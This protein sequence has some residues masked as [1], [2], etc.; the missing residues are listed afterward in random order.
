ML[1]S[2]GAL[3]F[4][5]GEFDLVVADYVFEHLEDPEASAAELSRVVKPGGWLCARTPNYYGY[6][7]VLTRLLPNRVHVR[8]LAASQPDRPQTDVFPT[9][10]ALNTKRRI[11]SAFS[12]FDVHVYYYEAE[13]GYFFNRRWVFRL[14]LIA[15]KLLPRSLHSSLFAFM[16]KPE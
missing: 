8:I 1:D 16:H 11:N 14:M 13:P 4:S 3:P 10:F 6:V 15:N 7:S 12:E 5:D 9:H 2:T